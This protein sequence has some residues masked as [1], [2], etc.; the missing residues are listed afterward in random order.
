[1]A[2]GMAGMPKRRHLRGAVPGQSGREASGLLLARS[3]FSLPADFGSMSEGQQF[4][5][6]NG[7]TLEQAARICCWD[8]D[9]LEAY[10][11]G[12]WNQVRHD[13][14][15]ISFK[16]GLEDRRG[17]ERERALQALVRDLPE[18]YRVE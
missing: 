13:V 12:V 6:I 9:M 2:V 3:S 4:R 5:F 11:L 18:R 14:W 7:R 15:N 1:M 8:V 10:R 16:L 17:A